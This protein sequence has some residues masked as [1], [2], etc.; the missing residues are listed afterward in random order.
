MHQ[1]D[2]QDDT[3]LQRRPNVVWTQNGAQV[4]FFDEGQGMYYGTEETGT[5]V[6]E[7]L[8]QPKTV[9]ALFHALAAEYDLTP[10]DWSRDG[11]PFLREALGVGVLQTSGPQIATKQSVP[12]E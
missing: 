12:L 10:S 7:L 11:M 3:V 8:E 6:W 4:F 5:R 2:L 9:A 1:K